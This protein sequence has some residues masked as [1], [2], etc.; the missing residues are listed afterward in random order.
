MVWL[1]ELQF[2]LIAQKYR[3][4]THITHAC[5]I[6]MHAQLFNMQF[7]FKTWKHHGFTAQLKAILQCDLRSLVNGSLRLVVI[8]QNGPISGI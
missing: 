3:S 7:A 8:P 5:Y 4:N 2:S 6:F 1:Q